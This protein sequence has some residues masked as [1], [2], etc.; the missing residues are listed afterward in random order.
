MTTPE[1]ALASQG[2]T[3]STS[4][5]FGDFPLDFST[6]SVGDNF[7]N[8]YQARANYVSRVNPGSSAIFS[9]SLPV[10]AESL[11]DSPASQNKNVCFLRHTFVEKKIARM[12]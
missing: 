9:D 5:G 6:T 2:F 10:H 3:T 8:I 12:V 4:Q 1:Y 11:I 7:N